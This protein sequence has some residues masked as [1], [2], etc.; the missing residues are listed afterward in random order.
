MTLQK[1]IILRHHSAGYIRFAMPAGFSQPPVAQTLEQGVR[2]F[3]GVFRVDFS[4]RTHKLTIRFEDTATDFNSIARALYDLVDELATQIQL[5][6]EPN[7]P[8]TQNKATPLNIYPSGWVGKKVQEVK[9]TF[10]AMGVVIRNRFD[11][12]NKLINNP[13]K[14]AIEFFNDVIV[15]YLIKLHWHLITQHWL[16]KPFQY[17]YEWMGVLYLIYLLVRAKQAAFRSDDEQPH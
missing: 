2:Q 13:E 12:E 9:E 5:T 4:T 6:P 11:G 8:N 1:N 16:R 7:R 17:R 15:L 14:V 10:T 3:R